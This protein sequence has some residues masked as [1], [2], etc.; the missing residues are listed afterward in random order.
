[1]SLAS[2]FDG[3]ASAESSFRRIQRFMADFDFPMRMISIFIFSILPEN[4]HLILVFLFY[5]DNDN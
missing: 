3:C 4:K 1:M 2:A 5:R